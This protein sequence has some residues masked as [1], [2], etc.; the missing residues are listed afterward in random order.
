MNLVSKLRKLSDKYYSKREQDKRQKQQIKNEEN[1]YKKLIKG[2]KESAK[3]GYRSSPIPSSMSN[4]KILERLQR[5]GLTVT[6][7]EGLAYGSRA[8]RW[9][10]EW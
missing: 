10:V 3:I 6:E 2:F 9:K 4:I 7:F 1:E 8:R 5:E